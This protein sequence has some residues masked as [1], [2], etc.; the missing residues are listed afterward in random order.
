MSSVKPK[1]NLAIVGAG[2]QGMPIL[3]ALIPPRKEN[4]SLRGLGVADLNSEAPGILFAYP[5]N[6]LSPSIS[7]IFCSFRTWTS[8]LKA[9]RDLAPIENHILEGILEIQLYHHYLQALRY[10]R[11]MVAVHPQIRSI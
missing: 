5:H 10:G 8:S 6:L 4:G 7:A 3:E 1:Y 9:P 2:Q 11:K